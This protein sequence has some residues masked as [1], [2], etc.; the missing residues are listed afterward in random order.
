MG[1]CQENVILKTNKMDSVVDKDFFYGQD[2]AP[3]LD[4]DGILPM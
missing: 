4:K 3:I 1:C 2:V